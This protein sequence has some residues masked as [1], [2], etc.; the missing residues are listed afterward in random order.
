MHQVT[1]FVAKSPLGSNWPRRQYGADKPTGADAS[2][3]R[4]EALK[5]RGAIEVRRKQTAERIFCAGLGEI[6]QLP[7]YRRAHADEI[8]QLREPGRDAN[9]A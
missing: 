1:R 2:D 8:D 3:P 6:A 7:G 5:V 9:Q 4:A